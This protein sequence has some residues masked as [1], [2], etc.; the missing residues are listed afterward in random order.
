MTL[1]RE[2]QICSRCVMDTTDPDITFDVQGVCNHCTNF[3]LNIRK[4][5]LPNDE[6]K[7][8]IQAIVETIKREGSGKKY[9]SIIGLSGGVD[10]SYLALTAKKYG[11]RPLAVH[12]DA[13]W[14]RDVGMTNIEN[15][16][17]VLGFDLFTHVVDWEE[18]KDLQVAYLKSGVENQDTP[19]DHVIFATLY[20]YASN[21]NIRYI[22][23]GSNYATES[24][25][26][27]AWGHDAM[28]LR[29]LKAIHKLYGTRKFKTYYTLNFFQ[30]R[31]FFP[32]IKKIRVVDI[33]N[34]VPYDRSNAIRVLKEEIGFQEYGKKHYESRFT[35][36]FQGYY[37]PIKFGYD[38]R[39]AHLSSLVL[40]G[41][42]SR[43]YAMKEIAQEV[44]SEQDL[45]VDREYVIKKLGLTEEEFSEIMSSPNMSFR[46]YPTSDEL[47]VTMGRIKKVLKP[48]RLST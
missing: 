15:I 9:D 25:L 11:L 6:G 46:D 2:Y 35:K 42:I 43:E 14:N 47:R 27:V 31:F 45:R 48:R 16:V 10:S 24:V 33:L 30:Y 17:K 41:Q 29:Q 39:R 8:R 26:P 38:K 3:D 40:S 19:Q 20:R 44:Y 23:S 22:L 5:W 21:N 34:Y 32:Y 13:G 36:F 28:D 12:V 37:L 18:M 7:S 1:I 4:H